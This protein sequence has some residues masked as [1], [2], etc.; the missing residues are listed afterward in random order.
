LLCAVLC[1]LAI[2]PFGYAQS[3]TELKSKAVDGD[4]Q[5]QLALAK[6]YHLGEGIEKDEAQA[7]RWW[8]MAA[9]HGDTAA[10]VNL[11]TAYSL[12]AGFQKTT[13]QPSA[14]TRKLPIRAMQKA[15]GTWHSS[16]TRDKAFR[17]TTL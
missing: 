17:K 9:E 10:E 7:V 8:E 6:A 16:I 15:S 2:L 14:G 13:P 11:G 5:A 1:L 4:V 3:I 12:G